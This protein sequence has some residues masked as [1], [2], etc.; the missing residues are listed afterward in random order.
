MGIL[1]EL[2][3]AKKSNPITEIDKDCSGLVCTECGMTNPPIL[4]EVDGFL[5]CYDC[6]E[7]ILRRKRFKEED[8]GTWPDSQ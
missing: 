2:L 5:E 1:S 8:D 7:A 3:G 4:Y 6:A